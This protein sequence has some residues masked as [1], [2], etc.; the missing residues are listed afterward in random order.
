MGGIKER[1]ELARLRGLAGGW[2][3]RVGYKRRRRAFGEWRYETMQVILGLTAG[4]KWLWFGLGA[5]EARKASWALAQFAT[6]RRSQLLSLCCPLL[7]PP[8]RPRHW[9][10]VVAGHHG[11]HVAS[12]TLPM[13]PE[14]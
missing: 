5:E 4:L 6:S 2:Q 8:L 14:T 9:T 7:T 1:K 12:A 3:R 11:R 13:R 10:G